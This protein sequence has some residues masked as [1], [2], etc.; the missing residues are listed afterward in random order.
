M[1]FPTPSQAAECSGPC[2]WPGY[3]PEACDCGLRERA[4]T[5]PAPAAYMQRL[6]VLQE[7]GL[8]TA[9]A[10]F[11]ALGYKHPALMTTLE[12]L[13]WLD[14]ASIEELNHFASA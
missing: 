10:V 5:G 8:I 1:K 12:F 7:K 4:C 9:A 14:V 13:D 3:N 2:W 11:G 6:L